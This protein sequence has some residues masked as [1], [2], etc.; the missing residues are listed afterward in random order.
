MKPNKSGV[1][2]IVFDQMNKGKNKYWRARVQGRI[3]ISRLFPFS[4]EGK[5]MA[6]KFIEKVIAENKE[7][8]Y[9]YQKRA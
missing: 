5:K 8:Y 4:D 7:K 3:N 9:Q 2:G 1:K 6:A